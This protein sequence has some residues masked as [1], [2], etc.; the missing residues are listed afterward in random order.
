[1]Y[2][3]ILAPLDGSTFSEC[4]LE[5]VKAI[6]RGCQ[7]PEVILL[8]VVEPVNSTDLSAY[9]EAGIDTLALMRDVETAAKGYIDRMTAQLKKDGLSVRGVVQ[10]GRAADVIM[11]LAEQNGVDLI[12]MSTHGRSGLGRWFMG[13]VAEKVVRHANVAVLTV[14]PPGCRQGTPSPA[15]S[16]R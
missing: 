8:R 7:V 15:A 9:A 3:K 6:A 10:V 16:P 13:S 1:M 14:A 2:H 11:A 5:H 12:I 4:S